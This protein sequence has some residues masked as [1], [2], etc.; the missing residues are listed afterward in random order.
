M[1][2]KQTNKQQTKGENVKP[3]KNGISTKFDIE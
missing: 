3:N 1:L 2:N